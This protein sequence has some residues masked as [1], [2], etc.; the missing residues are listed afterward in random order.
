[1]HSRMAPSHL[2]VSKGQIWLRFSWPQKEGLAANSFSF[3]NLLDSSRSPQ[4][5]TPSQDAA[6]CQGTGVPSQLLLWSRYHSWGFVNKHFNCW[7]SNFIQIVCWCVTFPNCHFQEWF[8]G[9]RETIHCRLGIS[10]PEDTI[11]PLHR[12]LPRF[13]KT[14]SFF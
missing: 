5:I 8:Q 7:S 6:A 10:L 12:C 11:I 3:R 2:Y 9:W 1:M 4:F 13:I 14:C